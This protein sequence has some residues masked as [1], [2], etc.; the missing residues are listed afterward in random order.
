MI[1]FKTDAFKADGK[2]SISVLTG[3]LNNSLINKEQLEE[4]RDAVHNFLIEL[5]DELERDA[6]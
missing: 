2:W 1:K 3:S 6:K 5:N 4:I